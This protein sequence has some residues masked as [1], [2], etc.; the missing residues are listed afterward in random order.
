M[1]SQGISFLT[2][3]GHHDADWSRYMN[4]T[5]NLKLFALEIC[6]HYVFFLQWYLLDTGIVKLKLLK[7]WENDFSD[8]IADTISSPDE[9]F[10]PHLRS[11]C[12]VHHLQLVDIG[13]DLN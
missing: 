7:L 5:N 12:I 4:F 8:E 3:S 1:K 10:R 13:Q 11:Q 9:C 2:K 6:L